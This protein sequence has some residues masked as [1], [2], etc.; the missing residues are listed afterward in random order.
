[1][2]LSLLWVNIMLPLLSI[3]IPV[4]VTVYT[5]SI[6]LRNQNRENHQPYLVLKK[7]ES[8]SKIDV[9]GYYLTLLGR[10]Y[11]EINKLIDIED[12]KK[13]NHDSAISIDL[14]LKN[15]GYGVATNIRFYDLLTGSK[16]HGTQESNKEKNQKLFTTF[17][18]ASSEE[19]NM[20]A[21]VI[22]FV[23]SEADIVK[24]DHNRL[25]CVYKDLNNNISSFIISVNVKTNNHYDFFAYQPSSKSYQNWIKQNNKEY[26]KILKKYDSL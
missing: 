19:K 25:L 15:I 24:E 12:I 7:V 6:R 13:I 14:I 1:M 26:K 8:L 4:F 23:E 21:R 17:D 20:Q 18:I 3:A 22:S 5:V 16:I 11:K 2:E 10:N 9:D